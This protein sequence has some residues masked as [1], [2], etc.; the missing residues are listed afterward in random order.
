L[1]SLQNRV[2]FLTV[3]SLLVL[4]QF[5]LARLLIDSGALPGT[6]AIHW[7]VSGAPDGF[8]QA[9]WFL[10]FIT[11]LYLSLLLP[12]GFLTFGTERK[13]LSQVFF[14]VIAS[15]SVFM[16]VL[17]SGSLFMQVGG[18]G[19]QTTLPVSVL[20]GIVS[21][22]LIVSV[23]LALAKPVIVLSDSL[24][25]KLYGLSL[26]RVEFSTLVGAQVTDLRTRDFGG[27]GIRYA[28]KTLA[29]IPNSGPGVLISTNFGESIAVRS[30]EPKLLVEEITKKIGS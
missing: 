26:L 4:L 10:Y 13:L 18:A 24:Q 1:P 15:V 21:I 23:L 11:A 25:I 2:L 6:I 20:L 12:L 19:Q 8:A 7:G 28:K 17:F 14:P 16:L 9:E 30:Q 29:F 22:V 27:L 3:W 5:V